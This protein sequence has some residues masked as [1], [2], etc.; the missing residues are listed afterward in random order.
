MNDV[1]FNITV[2]DEEGYEVSLK[3]ANTLNNKDLTNVKTS[4]INGK[5]G[6][7]EINNILFEK[8]EYIH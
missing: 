4:L 6:I 5:N 2:L 3:D 1:L 7:I 8:Q